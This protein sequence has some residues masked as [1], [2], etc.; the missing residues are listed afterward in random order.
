MEKH[1]YYSR[2]LEDDSEFEVQEGWMGECQEDFM[3]MEMGAKMYLDSFLSKGKT[4]LK[5]YDASAV[6]NKSVTGPGS[7]GIPSM[8]LDDDAPSVSSGGNNHPINTEQSTSSG[9]DNNV[10]SHE[11]GSFV[12]NHEVNDNIQTNSSASSGA[13]GFKMEK[14]KMPKF[15]GDVRDYAIFRADFKV[16]LT[17]KIFFFY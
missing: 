13:C 16:P 8:E 9:N 15:A 3:S 4:P 11:S 7:S 2:L 5:A 12:A 1:E 10:P 6:K 14:P 17:P